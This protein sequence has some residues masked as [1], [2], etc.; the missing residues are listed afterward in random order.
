MSFVHHHL[1]A[2]N[3]A[4]H[5]ERVVQRLEAAENENSFADEDFDSECALSNPYYATLLASKLDARAP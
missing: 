3:V 4:A 1:V 5:G 2:R